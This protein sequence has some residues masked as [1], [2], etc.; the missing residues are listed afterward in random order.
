MLAMVDFPAPD[1]PVNQ[2]MAGF[3]P[4]NVAR[5]ALSIDSGCH[6]TLVARYKLKAIM[7]APTVRSVYLS[8]TMNAPVRLF[9]LYE[10]KNTGDAVE[11]LQKPNSFMVRVAAAS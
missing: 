9:L 4:F 8:M 1:R 7:P 6:G 2:R 5:A 11:T 3:C 10:S